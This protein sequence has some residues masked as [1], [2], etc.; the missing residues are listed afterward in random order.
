MPYEVVRRTT[1]RAN[2]VDD[3]HGPPSSRALGTFS[4]GHSTITVGLSIPFEARSRKH[5]SLNRVSY[6]GGNDYCRRAEITCTPTISITNPYVSHDQS[7]TEAASFSFSIVS[8][9]V[10]SLSDHGN[11][12]HPP[13]LPKPTN[14]TTTQTPMKKN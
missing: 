3:L 7:V 6:E 13:D 12:I 8:Y 9:W 5:R 1:F 4:A 14:P 2:P 11:L 10:Q